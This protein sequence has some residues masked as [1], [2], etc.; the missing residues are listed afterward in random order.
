MNNKIALRLAIFFLALIGAGSRASLGQKPP[1]IVSTQAVK[2]QPGK[3]NFGDLARRIQLKLI[4]F[5][6]AGDFPGATV[7]VA[8]PDG[9]G[10]SVS[11]GYSDL[12]AQRS[13]KPADRMLAGSI[14][15]TFVSAVTLQLVDEGKLDL[16]DRIEKWLGKEP[17]FDRLPNGR[18]IT[19]RML[20]NHTSGIRE[21]V[22]NNDFIK[23]LRE[24]P[25]RIW[26]PEELIAFILDSKPLFEAGGGWSYADTNYILVGMIFERVSGRTV[27]GEVER[28]ILKP[29]KLK[30]TTPSDSRVIPGLI[31]GYVSPRSPFGFDGRTIIDDKFV[32]NPQMEWCGGGFASTAEDLAKW[33]KLL[34]E[35]RLLR[36][37]TVEQLLDAVPAKT[38]EGHK[39]GLGAQV[40]RTDWGVTYGHGGWFPGYLSEVEYFPK[41]RT[42]IAVQFNTDNFG[43][44]KRNTHGY[45]IEMARVVFGSPHEKEGP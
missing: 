33:A 27:Y 43:Q 44:L 19:L 45:V 24:Q 16:D 22:L 36:Q 5:R 15:K 37:T 23:A 30:D 32:I 20:M 13:M 1:E 18:Q 42:A 9:R 39:Y 12:E 34:Y 2:Q 28:R 6:D 41:H 10:M 25:D 40:R 14:G 11:I 38:G 3:V 7:G 31:P 26:K 21:H 8:M 29:F 4:E 17:W 35:G